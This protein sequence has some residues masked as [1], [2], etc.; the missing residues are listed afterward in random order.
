MKRREVK[1]MEIC[2]KC[3]EAKYLNEWRL[4]S[5]RIAECDYCGNETIV[6]DINEYALVSGSRADVGGERIP[7]S[8]YF[9]NELA[10]L[11]SDELEAVICLSYKELAKKGHLCKEILRNINEGE[12]LNIVAELSLRK[13]DVC[14]QN[15][16]YGDNLLTPAIASTIRNAAEIDVKECNNIVLKNIYDLVQSELTS[17]AVSDFLKYIVQMKGAHNLEP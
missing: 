14:K 1:E 6:Y 9:A 2:K 13:D 12:I 5:F 17:D 15:S 16:A 3:V 7:L 4:Y 10:K 8:I 11:D